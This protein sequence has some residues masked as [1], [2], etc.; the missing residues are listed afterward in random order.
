MRAFEAEHAV[1]AEQARYLAFGAFVL[2]NNRESIRVF[3]LGESGDHAER[4]LRNSW[5]VTD[6]A[7]A[8]DQLERL[9]SA[10][11][12]SPIAD[13]IFH[14][15][16]R[17]GNLEPIDEMELIFF[18]IDLTGLEN[19]YGNATRRAERMTDEFE[20]LMATL[21]ATK[22]ERDEVF[23]F[24]VLMLLADRVNQGLEAYLGAR[25]MLI[26]SFGFTEEELLNIPTLAAWDYG[27]AAIIARYGVAAGYLDEAVAWEHLQRAAERAAE[28]YSGWREFTAAHILGRALA[29]GNPSLDF[30]D[31]V[32]FLL[33]HPE[34]PFQDVEFHRA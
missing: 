20:L 19:V 1:T 30:R 31:A 22:E 9:S 6:H 5:S 3:A 17:A 29:F 23:E 24:F 12:Q 8:L 15:F 26:D 2:T 7:S 32:D 28:T 13:D 14:T 33:N 4:L 16:V 21:G 25:A 18:G 34:S 27:R 10:D 11:G